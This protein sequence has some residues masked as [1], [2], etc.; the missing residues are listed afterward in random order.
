MNFLL[1]CKLVLVCTSCHIIQ[2]EKLYNIQV[3]KLYVLKM[4][5]HNSLKNL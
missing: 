4:T 5:Y 3:I 2:F 1:F